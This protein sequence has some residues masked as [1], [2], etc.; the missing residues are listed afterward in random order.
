MTPPLRAVAELKRVKGAGQVAAINAFDGKPNTAESS[1]DRWIHFVVCDG[2]RPNRAGWRGWQAGFHAGSPS[3]SGERNGRRN[4]GDVLYAGGTPGQVAG[5]M[6]LN[7][8]IP[9]GM[10]SGGYVPVVLQVG[11]ASTTQ[12]AEWVSVSGN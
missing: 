1:E 11:D 9:N 12:G 2:R 7:L 5:L 3:S 4:A 6:Q 8:Q 10:Q